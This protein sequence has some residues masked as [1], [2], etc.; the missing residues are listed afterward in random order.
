V[1][2]LGGL[3]VGGVLYRHAIHRFDRFS[4]S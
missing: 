3:L 2:V 4:P 1:L